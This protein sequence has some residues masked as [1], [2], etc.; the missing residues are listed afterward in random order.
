MKSEKIHLDLE[1]AINDLH[2]SATKQVEIANETIPLIKQYVFDLSIELFK[3]SKLENYY[4]EFS[5]FSTYENH[6]SKRLDD[7]LKEYDNE[8]FSETNFINNE[9]SYFNSLEKKWY[10]DLFEKD[11]LNQ[12]RKAF[13]KKRNFLKEK[14]LQVN[15]SNIFQDEF[16]LDLQDTTAAEK[17]V[18]LSQLGILDFLKTKSPFNM[19]TNKLATVLSAITGEKVTTLQSYLNPIFSPEVDQ[20]KNPLANTKNTLKIKSTLNDVGFEQ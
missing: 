19:S 16:Y 8:Q 12:I 5:S 4:W 6:Y 14:T 3:T 10:L 7:Y 13:L 2:L 17:I 1:L 9:I 11:T 20:K 18:Y 15:N